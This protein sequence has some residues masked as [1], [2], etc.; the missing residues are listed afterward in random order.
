[1]T[2]PNAMPFIDEIEMRVD[3]HDVNR[4]LIRKCGDTGNVD[5]MVATQ[6]NGRRPGAKNG[7]HAGFDVGVTGERIG[8]NDVGIAKID[9]ARV[10]QIGHIVFVVVGACMAERKQGRSLTNAPGAKPGARAPLGAKVKRCAQDRDIGVDLGPVGLVRRPWQMSKCQQ[11]A[12]SAVRYRIRDS[13]GRTC[14]MNRSLEA[15]RNDRKCGCTVRQKCRLANLLR[16]SRRNSQK[17]R[18]GRHRQFHG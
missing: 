16:R 10:G 14:K 12:D 1:M 6:D 13:S 15:C 7:A 9:N 5:R 11:T 4:L 2:K 17:C 3:L 8:M 18:G